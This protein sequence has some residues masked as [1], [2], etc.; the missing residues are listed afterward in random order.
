[1]NQPLNLA[2]P[3]VYFL[4]HLPG[5]LLIG[6]EEFSRVHGFGAAGTVDHVR[7]LFHRDSNAVWFGNGAVMDVHLLQMLFD[8]ALIAC[9]AQQHGGRDSSFKQRVQDMAAAETSCACE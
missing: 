6:L 8:E 9:L 7:D 2:S 5:A 4:G 3:V 1:M